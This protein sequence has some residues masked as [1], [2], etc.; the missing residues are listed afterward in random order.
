M[1]QIG[2]APPEDGGAI[3][4]IVG[5]VSRRAAL[6][7]G[8]LAALL[9]LLAAPVLGDRDDAGRPARAAEGQRRPR[10]LLRAAQGA[11][12][13]R[14]STSRSS[15]PRGTL[16][17]PGRLAADRAARAADRG[18]CRSIRAVT[19]PGLIADATARGARRRRSR[20][21]A[22]GATSP[23][24]RAS[25][26]ARSRQLERARSARRAGR[27]RDV[28]RGLGEAKSLLAS[29]QGMLAAAS[30]RT[31]DV[32]RLRLGLTVGAGRRAR[33]RRRARRRSARRR[34]CWPDGLREIR[35]ARR[36]PVPSIASGQRA[37][38]DAQ[39]RL[40]LLRIPAQTTQHELESALAALDR[41]GAGKSDPAVQEARA[42]R[43]RGARG[44]GRQR[45]AAAAR[46]PGY[47]GLDAA[48]ARELRA[49]RARRASRSTTAV[50]QAGQ[51]ADVMQ[52]VADGAGRLVD[53]RPEHASRAGSGSSPPRSGRRATASPPSSRS[54]T[55]SRA[56]RSRCWP[57]AASCSTR[58]ARARRRCCSSSSGASARRRRGSAPSAISCASGAARSRRCAAC[59]R[60]S[61]S[62][63]GFFRSG[64]LIA[65]G[66]EGARRDAARRR[67]PGSSTAP[68][69][70]ARRASWCCPTCR[71]TT[72]ARTSIVDDVRAL[73]HRL[74]ARR[75]GIAAPVG[76]TAPEL[77]DFAR[78]NRTRVPL[79]IL[80][81]CLVTYLALIPILRSL[82]LPAIAVALNLLTVAA[83]FGLLTLL[84]VGDDPPMGGAGK[85]DVVTVTGDLRRHLRAV[86]RL[87]GL[88]AHA[89][90][91]G[92][93]AHAV[94][95]LGGRVRHLEDRAGRHRRRGDHGR[96]LR[97]LRAVE[98]LADPAARDRA[99]DRGADRRDDRPPRA[100]A[101]RS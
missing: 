58:A 8:L 11:L 66:L 39:A 63:P 30:S 71:P 28:G 61:G 20:S 26:P 76:G 57:P 74:R 36:R 81:I 50:R 15:A 13:A 18:D 93:R 59:A 64:Y 73:T 47:P 5:R 91:R 41:A 14:R 90:A 82:V 16:L 2:G 54:S 42:A 99:R 56:A 38:R 89:D 24:P 78:V 94:A 80:A 92:V 25:S 4:R 1:W 35:D 21:A 68:T 51:F 29:G 98:L 77:T 69:A 34:G 43:R 40:G 75:P 19:G 86:D 72:R 22:R 53:A 70:A 100:A 97:R 33:A 49:R 6:A 45:R 27:R 9:L 17:D 87:P 84:F 46:R 52:Q 12:R 96:R 31:G 67:S 37:L 88:P 3:S 48:L 85:L 62:R 79:L 60:S 101:R 10:R 65:A 83:A 23:P 44:R 32:D 7:A 55:A 95:R